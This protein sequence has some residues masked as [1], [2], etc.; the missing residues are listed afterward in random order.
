MVRQIGL[1]LGDPK[2]AWWLGGVLVNEV[3][4]GSV[5]FIVGVCGAPGFLLRVVGGGE[6]C[7]LHGTK[8]CPWINGEGD[9][10][11]FFVYFANDIITVDERCGGGGGFVHTSKFASF[12]TLNIVVCIGSDCIENVF[13]LVEVLDVG[14]GPLMLMS[15]PIVVYGQ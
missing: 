14:G 15:D 9:E 11:N 3:G 13:R 12:M 7:L 6:E 2:W 5:V 10:D 4:V 8:P 1:G